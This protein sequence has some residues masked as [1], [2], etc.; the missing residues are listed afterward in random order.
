MR[1]SELDMEARV[2][3]IPA[4]RTK[5]HRAHQVHLSDL[6]VEII[7]RVPRMDGDL[8][9]PSRKGTPFNG[10]TELKR[11]LDAAMGVSDWIMHDLRRTATTILAERL[12]VAPVV[13]DKILNH[14]PATTVSSAAAVYNRALYLDERRDALEALGRYIAGLVR[15][16]GAGNVVELKRAGL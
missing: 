11:R 13:A 2:W 5:S 6:A 10:F 1:W 16:R 8:V 7:E 9:F 15:P 4:E 12:K 14:A 3:S